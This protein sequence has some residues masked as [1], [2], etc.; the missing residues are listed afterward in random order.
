MKH[1]FCVTKKGIRISYAINGRVFMRG[2]FETQQKADVDLNQTFLDGWQKK[3]EP[4]E[5]FQEM[6]S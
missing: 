1:C 4:K 3:L 2:P 5:K 6:N